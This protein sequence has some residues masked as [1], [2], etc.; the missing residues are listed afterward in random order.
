MTDL[1]DA[2]R[3]TLIRAVP[4]A[5]RTSEALLTRVEAR[6]RARRRP[7]SALTIAAAAV[8]AVAT[9]VSVTA[10]VQHRAAPAGPATGRAVPSATATVRP[11]P[12]GTVWPQAVT[13]VPARLPDGRRYVPLRFLG[14]RTLLV[15]SWDSQERRALH[16]Y[17]LATGTAE[18][19]TSVTGRSPENFATGG[20]D[21][22]WWTIDGARAAVWV[23]PLAGGP[24]RKVTT[25]RGVPDHLAVAGGKVFLSATSGGLFAA[26]LTGGTA[27]PV[28]EAG[29]ASLL[30][31][32]WV[33]TDE[34][35][36]TD[37]LN[38]RTGK[39]N[40]AVV[41]AGEKD[42]VCD[43]GYCALSREGQRFVRRRDGS[44]ERPMGQTGMQPAVPFA[45]RLHLAATTTGYALIDLATG[46][47]GDF[48][49]RPGADG[50]LVISGLVTNGRLMSYELGAERIVIDLKN[51]P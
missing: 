25:F 24:P 50:G 12:V 28:T 29:E 43:S 44:Q 37:L 48:G 6:Y 40:R 23:A 14:D 30:D 47:A 49:I 17:D 26:P 39:R 5:P 34:P 10:L 21:V 22:A 2:L 42:I 46:R 38:L 16:N 35:A 51:I 9:V 4:Y 18:Q 7:W 27:E 33:G 19:I 1:E 3:R 13:R 32:P 20:H 41:R 45:G 36:F 11:V 8:A 15:M 31:Y